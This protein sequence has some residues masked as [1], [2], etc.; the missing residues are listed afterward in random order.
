MNR[1][2]VSMS[3]AIVLASLASGPAEAQR[4]FQIFSAGRGGPMLASGPRHRMFSIVDRSRMQERGPA[5]AARKG[6]TAA[7]A[8]GRAQLMYTVGHLNGEKLHRPLDMT[9]KRGVVGGAHPD[10]L[11]NPRR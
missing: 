4:S 3:A 11:W 8:R 2:T 7:P 9:L 6:R 5:F 10:F 1:V